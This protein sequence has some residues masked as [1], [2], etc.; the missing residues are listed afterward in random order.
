MFLSVVSGPS[1]HPQLVGIVSSEVIDAIQAGLRL[2]RVVELSSGPGPLTAC[3]IAVHR[4]RGSL[5]HAVLPD[6]PRVT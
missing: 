5:W 4:R 1:I 6:E 3:N 2:S